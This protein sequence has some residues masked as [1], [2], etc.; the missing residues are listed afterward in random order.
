M[1]PFI[2]TYLFLF[3]APALGLA[4]TYPG[5]I[6][7]VEAEK[8]QRF[9]EVYLFV[10]STTKEKPLSEVIFNPLTRE[11][12][13][14]YREKFGDL[15][16]ESVTY[17]SS[18][19]GGTSQTPLAIEE[20]TKKRKSFAEYMTKRLMEYHVDNYMK[21]QPQMKPVMEVK[22]KIQ[23]VKVEVT[24]EVRVN[25][26]YNFAGNTADVIV[27]NPWCE[28]KVSLEMDP[29]AF[30]PTDLEE[31]KVWTSKD[32]NSYWKANSYLAMTDGIAYADVTRTFARSQIATTLG[33]S[34]PFK[35]GGTSAREVKYILGFS[36]AF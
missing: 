30:G 19:I 33:L 17:R 15:D 12:K 3:L 11:F 36:H 21:T 6:R 14:K 29:N 7:D 34:S 2:F 28:S 20:E 4:S 9:Y 10:P 23:N 32:L 5:Y 25:I 31:T 35:E 18:A 8:S 1:R 22:E 27:D 16:T 24:Q 26:Q 13:E